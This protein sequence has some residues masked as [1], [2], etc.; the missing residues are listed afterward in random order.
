MKQKGKKAELVSWVLQTAL[1]WIRVVLVRLAHIL[2][3][4]LYCAARLRKVSNLPI[5]NLHVIQFPFF[6]PIEFFLVYH[7]V[8]HEAGF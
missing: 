5:A 8:V 2:R 6:S 4:C 7:A 3:C 1:N